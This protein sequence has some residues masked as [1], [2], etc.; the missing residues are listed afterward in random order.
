MSF[1]SPTRE[2]TTFENRNSGLNLGDGNKKAMK[3]IKMECRF[4]NT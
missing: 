3:I 1:S 4:K 2:K